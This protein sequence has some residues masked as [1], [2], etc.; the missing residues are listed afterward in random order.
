MSANSLTMT[1]VHGQAVSPAA[2][3]RV[4][5][6][7]SFG[8]TTD[9]VSQVE[10]IG[11]VPYLNNQFASPASRL[12]DPGANTSDLAPIQKTFFTNALTRQDQLRQRVAFALSEILV[13]SGNT[14]VPQ[15]MPPYMRLLSAAMHFRIIGRSCRTSR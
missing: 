5:E 8:P 12:P 6:Q 7:S 15:G 11:L 1:I 9:S 10:Q 13:T 2:A 4:L 14:I 3:V